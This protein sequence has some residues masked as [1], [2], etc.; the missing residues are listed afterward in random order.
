MDMQTP[1]ESEVIELHISRSLTLRKTYKPNPLA[2]LADSYLLQSAGAYYCIPKVLRGKNIHCYLW[3]SQQ[4][5]AVT[6]VHRGVKLF[7]YSGLSPS[8]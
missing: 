5:P 6:C 8:R 1:A 3:K 2:A 4:M 7:C